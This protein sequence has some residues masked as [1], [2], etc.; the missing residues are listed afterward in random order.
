[1]SQ[2]EKSAERATSPLDPSQADDALFAGVGAGASTNAR[3]GAGVGAGA[4]ADAGACDD[5]HNRRLDPSLPH[6]T[7]RDCPFFPC[8]E[9]IEDALFNC[10]FCFCPLYTLGANC[11]GTPVFTESGVKDCSRCNLP[12]LGNTGNRLVNEKFAM[13]SDL[14][15][16]AREQLC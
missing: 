7:N 3:A 1:M 14:A 5:A 4:E 2:P 11:G 6:F 15:Q 8:H 9:G 12:H 16:Q 13:L 10:L